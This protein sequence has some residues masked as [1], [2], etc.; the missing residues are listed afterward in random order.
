MT[1][2]S[3]LIESFRD[4]KLIESALTH[5]SFG[6]SKKNYIFERLEFL[7]DRV[8]GIVIA[9]ELFRLHPSE[10]EGSLA[11]RFARLVNKETCRSIF[12]NLNGDKYL[13]ANEKELQ[14]ATSNIYSD[15]CE[16]ILGALYSDQ[17][18]SSTKK[19]I[20]YHWGPFLRGDI[21]FG[22]DEKTKLQEWVQKKYNLVPEYKLVRKDGSEHQPI[23]YVSVE[24]PYHDLCYAEGP[25]R[26]IAEKNAAALMLENLKI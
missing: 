3:A 4:K 1:T 10:R 12:L 7:G 16:A 26:K 20:L 19:F 21:N 17:G 6:Y 22:V 23:F 2:L 14:M 25:T 9:E 13:K 8:L 11:K 18:L 15:A 24:I 5:P